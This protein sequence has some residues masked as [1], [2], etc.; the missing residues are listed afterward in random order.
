MVTEQYSNTRRPV[1][2]ITKSGK[3]VSIFDS[4]T[5]AADVVGCSTQSIRLALKGS[6]C[7]GHFWR[8]LCEVSKEDL[9]AGVYSKPLLSPRDLYAESR[10]IRV[11]QFNLDGDLIKSYR[12]LTQA[13]KSV[14]G[15][16]KGIQVAAESNSFFKG[17]YW[18]FG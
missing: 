8:E 9:S 14:G 5:A 17:F 15:Y 6:I 3:I 2:Q 12:S 4:I 18:S 16:V 1:V 11:N 13:A 10:G 7:S